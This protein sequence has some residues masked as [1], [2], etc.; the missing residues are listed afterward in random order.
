[1]TSGIIWVI[2]E[3]IASPTGAD[4]VIIAQILVQIRAS[5]FAAQLLAGLRPVRQKNFALFLST[6][7]VVTFF[8]A[9]RLYI[10]IFRYIYLAIETSAARLSRRRERKS[11]VLDVSYLAAPKSCFNSLYYRLKRGLLAGGIDG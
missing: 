9:R 4:V 2:C 7:R 6:H 11:V 10:P 8:A 3:V 5:C 1:M